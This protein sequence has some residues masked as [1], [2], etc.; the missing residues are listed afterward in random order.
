MPKIL[1]HNDRH[2][3]QTEISG[4]ALWALP[5]SAGLLSGS[6]AFS[7]LIGQVT[8]GTG[9][10]SQWHRLGLKMFTELHMHGLVCMMADRQEEAFMKKDIDRVSF[11]INILYVSIFLNN[12]YYH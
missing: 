5:S 12:I 3:C 8:M 11:L 2:I 10:T 1:A 7:H 6:L 4:A 9:V